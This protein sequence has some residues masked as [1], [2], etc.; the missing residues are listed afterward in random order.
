MSKIKLGDNVR[1]VNENMQGVVT[2][3]HGNT[4]GV[5]IEDDFEIPVLLSEIV[6]IES[7]PPVK[8]NQP[9]VTEKPK[10]VKV[11]SGYHLAFE[12]T[13]DDGLT[14]WFHNSETDYASIN[15]FL[16]NMFIKHHFVEQEQS[17]E[18]GKFKLSEFNQWPEFGFIITG[19]KDNF[20]APVLVH[21][22]LKFQAKVFH[23]GFKQCYFLGKQAYSFRIDDEVQSKQL[24]LL[25]Q[26]DF[27]EHASAPQLKPEYL[28]EQWINSGEIDLHIDKLKQNYTSLKASEILEHQ[29]KCLDQAV[30][31]AVVKHKKQLIVIHGVGNQ[32]L[33]NKVRQYC[34]ENRN[35]IESCLDADA[36]LYGGG[37]SIIQFN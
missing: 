9:Q 25:K 11:H 34:K 10:F 37:A 13:S 28:L 4:A 1:F 23:A 5:T 16:N 32:Y 7:E 22:K 2:S 8:P 20:E 29:L 21:K 3:I 35:V 15:L 12:R 18:L 6:K 27:S 30:Q 24:A 33:K 19:I 14:L 31:A 26:K 36:L 17:I